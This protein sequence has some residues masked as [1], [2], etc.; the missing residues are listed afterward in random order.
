ML[1]V[2]SYL[3]STADMR[4]KLKTSFSTKER[5]GSGGGGSGDHS[6]LGVASSLLGVD[7]LNV[8]RAACL[9][10]AEVQQSPRHRL[11]SLVKSCFAL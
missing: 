10:P 1:E 8:V 7:L 11:G 5:E 9:G 3:A 4:E 2:F 6:A